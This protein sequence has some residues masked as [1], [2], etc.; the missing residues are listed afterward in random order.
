MCIYI[1]KYSVYIKRRKSNAIIYITY[2]CIFMT[3]R[4]FVSFRIN[5]V[6]LM[7][8]WMRRV[9]CEFKNAVMVYIKRSSKAFKER[10]KL[11]HIMQ[12]QM[13]QP[14]SLLPS[15]KFNQRFNHPH[16][17]HASGQCFH[18]LA[19][20]AAKLLVLSPQTADCSPFR[21][22]FMDLKAKISKCHFSF[23]DLSIILW[24]TWPSQYG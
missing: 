5:Q 2:W 10:L 22:S 19:C 6:S 20:V 13:P 1:Y 12:V 15:T 11:V 4:L 16:W 21:P 18:H 8:H 17:W 24:P 3:Q 23:R 9:K 7:G 14:S